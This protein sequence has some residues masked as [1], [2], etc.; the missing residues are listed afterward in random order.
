MHIHQHGFTLAVEVRTA[1]L[2][3]AAALRPA[4]LECG[5]YGTECLRG[6]AKEGSIVYGQT[7]FVLAFHLRPEM[8]RTSS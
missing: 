3:I 8:S 2:R 6:H 1:L 5:W 7:V 4:A